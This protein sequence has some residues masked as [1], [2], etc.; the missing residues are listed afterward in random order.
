MVFSGMEFVKILLKEMKK[1]PKN[2][3]FT[4]MELMVTIGIIAI[5]A[6]IGV[7]AYTK[8][9]PKYKLGNDATN[10][11]ADLEMAKLIAKRENIY[12]VI[13]FTSTNY[14]IFR[15]T[16]PQ[17]FVL[18]ANESIIEY[19]KLS[20]G[21]RFESTGVLTWF[22]GSGEAGPANIVLKGYGGAQNKNIEVQFLGRITI[23]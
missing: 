17:N 11:K 21:N 6:A 20:A 1:M 7:P 3:G 19:Q 9:I 10:L 8:W 12:V 5:L 22:R 23:N 4:A 13:R 15:D 14:T 16:N 2:K 18:N